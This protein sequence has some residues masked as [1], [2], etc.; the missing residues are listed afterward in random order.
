MTRTAFVPAAALVVALA[1]PLMGQQASSG[2]TLEFTGLVLINGF[3][4]DNTV[5]NADVPQFAVPDT[6]GRTGGIGGT[7]RQTR[8]GFFLTQP[9]VLGGTFT[10]EVDVDFAGGQLGTAGRTFPLLRLRRLVARINWPHGEWLVG[11]ESHLLAEINP[12]SLA[13]V[14][15]PGFVTAGNLWFWMPQLRGTY[16][17]GTTVRI[18]AQGAVI[19]PM[20]GDPQ[21]TFTT[22][23]D[24]AEKSGRPFLQ[25]RV[26]VSWGDPGDANEVGVAAHTGWF[27]AT[28]TTL[29][30]SRAVAVNGRVRVGISEIRGEW[31]TGYGLATLGGG[32]IGRNFASFTGQPLDDRGGWMQIN[33]QPATAWEIGGGVG[34]DE[35][36]RDELDTTDPTIR[37][38][39]LVWEAH[40]ML[41]PGGPVLLGVEYR[42]FET[43]YGGVPTLPVVNQHIN[44]QAGFRF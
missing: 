21:G 5:N 11:Q 2:R 13:S 44:L 36:D 12:K 28:D 43:E 39:N 22:Q 24:A 1:A 41:H 42:R 23:P 19:A 16:E 29:E 8:L 33:I 14:A 17:L 15:T 40:L 10:G 25:G 26:R 9:D 7:A 20:T 37:L 18:A 38:R 4:N 3:S 6:A 35:P 31:Y 30:T 32:G 27:A 34:I